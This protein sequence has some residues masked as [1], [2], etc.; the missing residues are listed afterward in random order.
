MNLIVLLGS[1]KRGTNLDSL[2]VDFVSPPSVVLHDGNR[3]FVVST[4]CSIVSLPWGIV[5]D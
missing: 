4:V 1:R 3:P 5:L 2:S